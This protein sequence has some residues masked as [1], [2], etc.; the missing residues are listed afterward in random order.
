MKNLPTPPQ[1][2][3]A[4]C[5][6]FSLLVPWCLIAAG[7]SS[8]PIK[9]ETPPNPTADNLK[10]ILAAYGSFCMTERKPPES[11]EDLKPALAKWG[12]PD[13]VLR[14]P[15]DGQPFVICWRVDL[16]KP[17]SWAKSTPVLAYEKRGVDGQRYVLTARRY[18]VLMRDRDF[19]QASFPPGHT[20]NF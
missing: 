13:E 11:A 8:A 9:I 16:L 6:R 18:V 17:E 12:N 14:S 10:K 19:R 1:R 20:P 15:R 4:L 2:R 3:R 5:R 7:C